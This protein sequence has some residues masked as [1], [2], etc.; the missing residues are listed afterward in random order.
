MWGKSQV[1][2]NVTDL[3]YKGHGPISPPRQKTGTKGITQGKRGEEETAITSQEDRDGE[4]Q[5]FVVQAIYLAMT[6]TNIQ[7]E[8]TDISHV[9]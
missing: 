8:I 3:V 7:S 9:T 1:L 2:P 5:V 4:P 6:K